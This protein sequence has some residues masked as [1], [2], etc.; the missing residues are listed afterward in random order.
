MVL[1]ELQ[2]VIRVLRVINGYK[3]LSQAVKHMSYLQDFVQSVYLRGA[4]GTVAESMKSYKYDI[5]YDS[6]LQRA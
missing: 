5:I 1:S 4:G 2:M 6:D 3:L